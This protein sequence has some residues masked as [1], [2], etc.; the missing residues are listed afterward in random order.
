MDLYLPN[1][2]KHLSESGTDSEEFSDNTAAQEC[3]TGTSPHH[4]QSHVQFLKHPEAIHCAH[5]KVFNPKR[6]EENFN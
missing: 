1:T 6:V 3:K 5:S 2:P 4:R